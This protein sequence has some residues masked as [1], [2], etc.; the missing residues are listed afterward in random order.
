MNPTSPLPFAERYRQI[1]RQDCQLPSTAYRLQQRRLRWVF[2]AV[3]AVLW[4][5]GALVFF[6]PLPHAFSYVLILNRY[7]HVAPDS[8]L[9]L[10]VEHYNVV[11]FF[12]AFV[13]FLLF[14]F[15]LRLFAFDITQR[16]EV[17]RELLAAAEGRASAGSDSPG[18]TPIKD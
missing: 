11:F 15:S 3:F 2:R 14:L 4:L 8:A 6:R 9:G 7:Q 5:L 1:I 18:S 13:A 17:I 12:V 10:M 16:N